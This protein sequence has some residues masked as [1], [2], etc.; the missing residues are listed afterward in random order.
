[1]D[2]PYTP[3]EP[4]CALTQI[5]FRNVGVQLPFRACRDEEPPPLWRVKGGSTA[6]IGRAAFLMLWCPDLGWLQEQPWR[7]HR[8]EHLTMPDYKFYRLDGGGGFTAGEWMDV[9]SDADAI[10]YVRA[11][12][13]AGNS[14]IWFGSRLVAKIPG[15]GRR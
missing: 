3:A 14:E 2:S 13:L 11:M 10:A 6:Q 12:K 15:H 7:W 8:C 4:P 1:M 5:S 9:A